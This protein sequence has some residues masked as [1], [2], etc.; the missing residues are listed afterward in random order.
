MGGFSLLIIAAIVVSAMAPAAV[1][2]DAAGPVISGAQTRG[3]E[4]GRTITVSNLKDQGP[5]SLRAAI[6]ADEPRIIRFAVA[7]VIRLRQ[8]LKIKHSNV[9]IAGESAPS[10]GI[11]L[12]GAPLRIRANDVIVRHLRIRVGDGPGPSPD[13]RDGITILGKQ[14]SNP[15]SS[16]V[17]ID[18]CSI[19]WAIDENVSLWFPGIEAVTLRDSIIAEGLDRSLHAKGSHSMGMLV[20]TGARNVLI[21]GNLFAHNRWRN[22]V[23]ASGVTALVAN[24]LIYDAGDQ[25]IHLYGGDYGPTLASIVGNVVRTG[26]SS[27]GDF[28]LW[29]KKGPAP[30]SRIHRS[31]NDAGGTRVFGA[32][33]PTDATPIFDPLVDE[34]PVQ[35]G[36]DI[37]ILPVD[38]VMRSVLENAGARP[39]DRDATDRRIVGEV[40]AGGGQIR[41]TV[42]AA[43]TP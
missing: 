15:A 31:G 21:Q 1:A 39:W 25:A 32:G 16:N 27:K 4:G 38:A 40:T 33:W 35:T 37:R 12:W 13:D 7:G 29:S 17:L 10:P 18:H 30:G 8:P 9:T 6:E 36:A 26:P 23:L 22:P 5:G 42:P 11:T 43:E 20:G 2:A 24:N 19:S 14:N 28:D 3:G 41:D 34:P